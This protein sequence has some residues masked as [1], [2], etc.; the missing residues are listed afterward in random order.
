MIGIGGGGDIIGAVPTFLAL[1]RLGAAPRLAGLT[2]KRKPQDPEARPRR[3]SE[4]SNIEAVNDV[5]G[6]VNSETILPGAIKHVEADAAAFLGVPVLT[7][8]ITGGAEQVRKGLSD[9][10][11]RENIRQVVAVDVG[12]D[13]L[14][15]GGEPTVR[16]PLCDQIMMSALSLIDGTVLAVAGLGS[17]GELPLAD[18][19]S[20]FECLFEGGAYLGSLPVE[21][22]DLAV[23]RQLLQTGKSE[24]SRC[25]LESAAELS[26]DERLLLA[27]SLNDGR[28]KMRRLMGTPVKVALREGRRVGELSLL[29]AATLFFR[30]KK[31]YESNLFAGLIDGAMSL[32][33]VD[34]ALRKAGIRT[35]LVD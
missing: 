20:R 7:I 27:A 24:C 15:L 32:S 22:E 26:G 4:F 17:D 19:Q 13:A 29:T 14:C 16:S 18:F 3:L 9:Y 1:Q 5:V 35:E 10:L 25:L 11:E 30:L 34:A 31:V 23:L 2:W 33:Q 6:I 8:D 12:G 21:V 28:V